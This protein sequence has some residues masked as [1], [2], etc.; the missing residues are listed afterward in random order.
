MKKFLLSNAALMALFACLTG[1]FSCSS[2]SSSST[3]TIDSI[4]VVSN[5]INGP[6]GDYFEVVEKNYKATI[7]GSVA[8]INI[9]IKRVAEGGPTKAG[10]SYGGPA[11]ILELL[12]E[13][14]NVIASR[15][16]DTYSGEEQLESAFSLR[17]GQSSSIIFNVS[18]DKKN[19]PNIK[20][21]KVSSKWDESKENESDQEA[22]TSS[23][24]DISA[25][26][27]A[28]SDDSEDYASSSAR[29]SSGSTDFDA[30]L[31]E[32]E[33][34]VNKYISL[35]KKAKAGDMEAMSE[36]ASMMESAQELSSK[37]GNVSSDL[38][39]SQVARYQRINNKLMKA[40]QEL[41]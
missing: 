20:K 21:I 35:L 34:Y 26:T 19:F 8:R 39:A 29:S 23:H 14:D 15:D 30:W 6:L 18:G 22:T 40:A 1:L 33:N 7:D 9:E 31:T 25:S 27:D 5:I 2:D 38:T 12:D 36:Y 37:I 10:Y 32:Y 24:D 28:S 3:S 11:L 16:T 41:N 13:D 17:E 4:K